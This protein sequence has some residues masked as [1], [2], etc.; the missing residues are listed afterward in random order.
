MSLLLFLG[1]LAIV[2]MMAVLSYLAFGAFEEQGRVLW[3]R[4]LN[5]YLLPMIVSPA[6]FLP[7]NRPDVH[8]PILQIIVFLSYLIASGF[9]SV[10]SMGVDTLYICA[11]ELEENIL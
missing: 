10:Y 11:C 4:E 5:Y 1:K 3:Q 7:L 8:Y 6:S 9:L 2:G